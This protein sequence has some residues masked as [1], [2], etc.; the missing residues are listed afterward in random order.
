[1]SIVSVSAGPSSPVFLARHRLGLIL[2]LA[3]AAALL[4]AASGAAIGTRPGASW[5]VVRFV[6]G[7]QVWE[8]VASE[9]ECQA[10]QIEGGVICVVGSAP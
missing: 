1:M 8:A 10:A 3:L 7:S 2:I 5:Q 9:A 4:M 6:E